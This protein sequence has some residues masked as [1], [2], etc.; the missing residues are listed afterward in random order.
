VGS[1][2]RRAAGPSV[3]EGCHVAVCI[4]DGMWSLCGACACTRGDEPPSIEGKVNMEASCVKHEARYMFLIP[5]SCSGWD[6]HRDRI[7]MPSKV[8]G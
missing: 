8:V 6:Q 5:S 3:I 1:G 4:G 7:V 2:G